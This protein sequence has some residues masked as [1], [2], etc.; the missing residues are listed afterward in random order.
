MDPPLV[1]IVTIDNL[2]RTETVR[3]SLEE[4]KLPSDWKLAMAN[5]I[6]IYK[7]G[8]K[9]EAGNYRPIWLTSV[10]CKVLESIIKY[11]VADHLQ[12]NENVSDWFRS[13][14]VYHKAQYWVHYCS[15]LGLCTRLAT[16]PQWVTNSIMVF[17]DDTKL[18]QDI[19]TGRWRWCITTTGSV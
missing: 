9:T 17:A 2:T 4:G 7:K 1:Y 6:L 16:Q 19:E 10:P 12:I 15:H 13:S 18:G 11:A 3:K 14:V 5:V 8:C